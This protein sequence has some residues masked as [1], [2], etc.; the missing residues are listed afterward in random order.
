MTSIRQFLAGFALLGLLSCV[1]VN[2]YFPEAAA[3][4]ALRGVAKDILETESAPAGEAKPEASLNRPAIALLDFLLPA[5]EAA[6]KPNVDV[7][8]P[9]ALK[10]RGGLKDRQS[11]LDPYYRSGAIGYSNSGQPVPRDLS[12]VPL[13]ERTKLKSLLAKDAQDR[14]ALFAEIA[15]AN[16]HPEW[17]ANLRDTFNRVFI[18]EMPRGYWHQDADSNWRQK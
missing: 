16:G 7:D 10:L 11:E 12:K 18:E 2:I 6:D 8:T 17:E 1:T 9:L 4:E 14:R 3:E 15:R 5:V 13:A